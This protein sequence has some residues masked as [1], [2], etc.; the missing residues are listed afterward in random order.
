[1]NLGYLYCPCELLGYYLV[2]CFYS[3]PSETLWC[4]EIHLCKCT[5]TIPTNFPV[6][7]S[8]PFHVFQCDKSSGI[9][10]LP[11]LAYCSY[12]SNRS[13]VCSLQCRPIVRELEDFTETGSLFGITTATPISSS[14]FQ[15]T[16]HHV[17]HSHVL[18]L[19]GNPSLTVTSNMA[20]DG[21]FF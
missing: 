21:R 4:A 6:H 10:P 16:A 12:S 19:A 5:G 3:N 20:V 7:R 14:I 11:I 1:M 9:K 8:R 2:G 13:R 18:Q 15:D 17:F